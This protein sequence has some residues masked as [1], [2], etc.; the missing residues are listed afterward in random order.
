MR[1]FQWRGR[2]SKASFRDRVF[3][4]LREKLPAATIEA[5]GDLDIRITD[6][7]TGKILNVWLGRA[8]EEFSKAPGGAD[9]IIARHVRGTL[10][11]ADE[12][13]I[14]LQRIIPTIMSRDWLDSQR[15]AA[16]FDPLVEPYNADLVIIYA[17]Y[18]DG[19][20]YGHR[21]DFEPLGIS[22]EAIRKQALANLRRMIEKIKV[23]GSDGCYI[24][25]AGGTLDSSLV[26]LDEVLENAG[27]QISGR[28]LIGVSDRGS[29][30]VVDDANPWAVVNAS[31]GVAKCYRSE[32]YA[33]S[34]NLYQRLGPV[35]EPLDS[36]PVDD[37][38]PI[39][40]L[41]VI[42]IY[43]TKKGGGAD[44]VVIVA[45]PLSADARSMF[46]LARKLDAYLQEI[47]TD[48]HRQ[49]CGEARRDTTSIIVRLH[50]DSDPAIEEVLRTA[51][52]WAENRNASLQVKNLDD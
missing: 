41:E 26:L 18:R 3:G 39:P 6:L 21:S 51:V 48:V 47:N 45:S 43:A 32:Q 40:N 15:Q 31:A 23:V 9:E 46:R 19:I 36:G 50:P 14:E 24:L 5:T 7:P 8:Y 34:M 35:W 2:T 30:W 20:Q 17:D 10:A 22:V 28:P 29:F 37:A 4:V 13:A 49:E 44:L 1:L 11:A 16:G 52:G 12:P 38:H 33:I 42:D 27:L 25:G